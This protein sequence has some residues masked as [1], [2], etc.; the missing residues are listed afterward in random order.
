MTTLTG[1]RLGQGAIRDPLQHILPMIEMA[2]DIA[3]SVLR[4]SLKEMMPSFHSLDADKISSLPYAMVGRGL[5]DIGGGGW[6]GDPQ[7]QRYFPDD[8]DCYLLLAAAE[9]LL[10]TKDTAFL[11]ERVTYWNSNKSHTVLEALQRSVEFVTVDIGLGAHNLIRMLSSD[12][13]DGF[14]AKDL[15]P[16]EAYNV[17][18]SVLTAFENHAPG[19]LRPALEKRGVA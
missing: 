3:K 9:Y 14:S 6:K 11:Q 5:I 7:A 19:S 12:W 15:V 13:D 16:R 10:V 4:Y 2:P 18:E 1:K 17:S 8:L